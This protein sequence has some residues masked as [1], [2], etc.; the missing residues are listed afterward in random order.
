MKTCLLVKQQKKQSVFLA[1][2]LLGLSYQLAESQTTGLVA[3][4]AFNEGTGTTVAD[5]SG[6][7]LTGTISGA[8]WT[9][10]GKFGNALA[11]NGTSALVTIP[12]AALLQLTV[13]MTL[14]AWVNPTAVNNAWRD[15]IY[16][17]N[18]NYYLEGMSPQS[19][20][21]AMGGTFSPS[22]L[23]GTAALTVNTWTHLAATYDG[24][25]MKLYVNGAQVGS[26]AQTGSIATSTN[27]LQIG[28]DAT[29]GQ[30][31]QGMIDEV[32]IYSRALAQTE[33]QTDMN[34]PVTP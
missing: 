26:S 1:L 32:R 30:Y 17:A 14:E 15:I 25:T 11:F 27:P 28:G 7:G 8:A 24:T 33:I 5:S 23:Y 4:Y 2:I 31:F 3:A 9:A 34:T 6:H 10:G 21:P 12:N 20:R 18:D 19:Q 22:P 16:K 29:Y 13:G